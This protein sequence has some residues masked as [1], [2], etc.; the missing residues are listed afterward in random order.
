MILMLSACG[1]DLRQ[2]LTAPPPATRVLVLGISSDPIQVSAFENI[3]ANALRVESKAVCLISTG[4]PDLREGI[5]MAALQEAV[6]HAK[7]QAVIVNRVVP[8]G[9]DEDQ[10]EN[11]ADYLELAQRERSSWRDLQN[12]IVESRLFLMPNGVEVWRGQSR[13]VNP[14]GR[15]RELAQA[16]EHLAER[17]ARSDTIPE[18]GEGG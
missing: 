15:L 13:Q 9:H 5:S 17:L 16:S 2:P 10:A 8:S 1:R 4:L 18:P 14:K 3:F 11:L 12:G 6:D 7:A